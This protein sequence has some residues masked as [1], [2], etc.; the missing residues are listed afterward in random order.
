MLRQERGDVGNVYKV[1][2]HWSRPQQSSNSVVVLMHK[3]IFCVHIY[4]KASEVFNLNLKT[5]RLDPL[6]RPATRSTP[7]P[8][9]GEMAGMKG[10][11]KT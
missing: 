9:S 5:T 10:G 4:V 1:T 2:H 7:V 11:V 3:S 8:R 6:T